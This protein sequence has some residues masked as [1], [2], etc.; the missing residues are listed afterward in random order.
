MNKEVIATTILSL[1]LSGCDSNSR[2]TTPIPSNY[3]VIKD[4]G[5]LKI[6]NTNKFKNYEPKGYTRHVGYKT[7]NGKIIHILTQDQL[8]DFQIARSYNI[9]KHYLTNDPKFAYNKSEVAN[10]MANNNGFCRKF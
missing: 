5:F 7:S 3:N 1:A 10:A 2:G 6:E 9:L 4:L 8:T